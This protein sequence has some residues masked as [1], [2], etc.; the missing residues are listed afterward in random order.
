[1]KP[2]YK[3]LNINKMNWREMQN[4]NV[5]SRRWRLKLLILTSIIK[6]INDL[7]K[8]YRI[9]YEKK[10]LELVS[11]LDFSEDL[12]SC[13]QIHSVTNLISL[14]WTVM[15]SMTILSLLTCLIERF[16]LFFLHMNTWKVLIFFLHWKQS[17]L[18]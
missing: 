14:L 12:T 10:I 15:L 3:Y 8:I 17:Y 4:L 2:E 6:Q 9:I 13:K 7:L 11:V 16:E 5:Q 1:M 18:K